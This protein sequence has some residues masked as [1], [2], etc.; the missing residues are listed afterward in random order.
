MSRDADLL[1]TPAWHEEVLM[2]RERQPRPASWTGSK[3]R[4]TSVDAFHEDRSLSVATE[5]PSDELHFRIEDEVN[6][7]RL[8]S[9]RME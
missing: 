9:A 1:G 6:A 5:V 2:E 8:L 7:A 4:R 3:P